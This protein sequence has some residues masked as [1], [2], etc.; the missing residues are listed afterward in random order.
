MEPWEIQMAIFWYAYVPAVAVF[1]ASALLWV[2]N[3]FKCFRNER[4]KVRSD[5]PQVA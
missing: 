1:F 2:R 4:K 3:E 5:G